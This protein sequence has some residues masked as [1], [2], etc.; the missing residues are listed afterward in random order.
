[1]QAF[2]R[3]RSAHRRNLMGCTPR[4]SGRNS[5]RGNGCRWTT[6]IVWFCLGSGFNTTIKSGRGRD[7]GEGRILNM[8]ISQ[9]IAK[10]KTI[11]TLEL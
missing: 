11:R 5:V 8:K 7:R 6:C 9:A 1:M 2:V 10:K 3:K 4:R